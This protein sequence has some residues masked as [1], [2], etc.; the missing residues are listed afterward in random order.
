VQVFIANMQRGYSVLERPEE[1][2][3]AG[4]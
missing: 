4:D 3:S 1:F 2:Q